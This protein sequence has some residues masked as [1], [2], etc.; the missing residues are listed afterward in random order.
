MKTQYKKAK[1]FCQD[2][3]NILLL[4]LVLSGSIKFVSAQCPANID[5]ETGTFSGWTCYTGDVT[6][7]GGIN[8]ISLN[9]VPG[10][11][12]GRHAML[13]SVP[14][15]GIDQ[16]GGF[17][18]NCP[19]GSGHSVKIG[20]NIGGHEAEGVSY[21]FTIPATA[22]KFILIYYYAVVFQDPVHQAEQQLRLQIEIRNITEN[23][24][25]NS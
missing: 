9:P 3:L 6:A 11:V 25:I 20:N 24:T 8:N 5:F 19:N 2:R 12:S 1:L 14:G 22:N 15:N 4:L 18:Q 7:I 23:T 10:P 13:T 17:P 16:Y 21:T